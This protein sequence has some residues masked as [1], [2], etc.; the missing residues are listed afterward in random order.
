M[1]RCAGGNTS[2]FLLLT[3]SRP[4]LP[5]HTRHD[6]VFYVLALTLYYLLL[7][8]PYLKIKIIALSL[9]SINYVYVT[10][11]E[12]MAGQHFPRHLLCAM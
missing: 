10:T 5:V 12:I 6:V 3:V 7:W 2:Y 9:V 11:Y 4:L 8:A 1:V